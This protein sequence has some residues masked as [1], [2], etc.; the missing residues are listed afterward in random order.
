MIYLG[1]CFAQHS[2]F[3]WWWWEWWGVG[4]QEYCLLFTFCLSHQLTSSLVHS[5]MPEVG[6]GQDPCPHKRHSSHTKNSQKYSEQKRRGCNNSKGPDKFVGKA[7]HGF[8]GQFLLTIPVS[9][10]CEC[11]VVGFYFFFPFSLS[12]SDMFLQAELDY[13]V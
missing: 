7:F 3:F 8:H 4:V 9:S 5:L 12:L 11:E 6:R 2:F 10:F 1:N 13:C